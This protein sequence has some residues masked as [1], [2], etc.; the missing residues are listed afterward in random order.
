MKIFAISDLHLSIASN[1]PMD[2]FGG[3]WHGYLEKIERSWEDKVGDDDLVLL[4]G[5]LSWGMTL[6]EAKPDIEFLKKFKGKKIIIRGNHDGFWW[7]SISN[8]RNALPFETYALQNDAMRIGNVTIAG[9]RGWQTPEKEFAEDDKKIY[10]RELI[11]MEMS[12][13]HMQKIK[14]TGDL[15]VAMIH[16]PPYNTRMHPSPF[17]EL[18]EKYDVQKVVYG[19]LHGKSK[20]PLFHEKN[21]IEYYLTSCDMLDNELIQIN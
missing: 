13:E 14:K 5:D 4:A 17:T 11:R 21:G 8:V 2:I 16:Y 9:S 20:R 3:N 15:T 1:K 18:F 7:K 12:L 10:D 19:H 6:E